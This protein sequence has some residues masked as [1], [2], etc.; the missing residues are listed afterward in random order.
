MN[1]TNH[2]K[3]AVSFQRRIYKYITHSQMIQKNSSN[4]NRV[5]FLRSL[6]ICCSLAQYLKR[7]DF[8]ISSKRVARDVLSI[9]S[10][11]FRILPSTLNNSFESS[12]RT[13][14]DLIREAQLII[15]PSPAVHHL[16]TPAHA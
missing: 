9:K 11:L 8:M 14:E 15:Q 6:E 3:K 13:I 5:E 12:Q 4:Y 7:N 16:N 1:K 10:H 2:T